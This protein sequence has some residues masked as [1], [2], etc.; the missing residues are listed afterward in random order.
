MRHVEEILAAHSKPRVL[1]GVPRVQMVAASLFFTFGALVS[2]LPSAVVLCVAAIG[3]ARWC[4]RCRR[5]GP[6][7]GNPGQRSCRVSG[8]C[9]LR[10]S[11]CCGGD[12]RPQ[13]EVSSGS[14]RSVVYCIRLDAASPTAERPPRPCHSF[15]PARC[16]RWCWGASN[17]CFPSAMGS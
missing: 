15:Q 2:A 5:H 11:I 14:R 9:R 6:G 12:G 7:N 1:R 10:A 4:R 13:V 17:L 8:R 3:T 16:N